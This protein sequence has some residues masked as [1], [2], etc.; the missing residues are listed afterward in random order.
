MLVWSGIDSWK[1]STLAHILAGNKA[2]IPIIIMDTESLWA[3][4]LPPLPEARKID[5]L[6]QRIVS[7]I[8][9]THKTS[10]RKWRRGNLK[11]DNHDFF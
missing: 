6:P 1:A 2:D 5:I 9:P 4:D 8:L 3:I 11:T 10:K 7:D